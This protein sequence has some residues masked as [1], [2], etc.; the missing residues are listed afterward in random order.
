MREELL[1]ISAELQRLKSEGVRSV[2]VSEETMAKL[3]AAVE[4]KKAQSSVTATEQTSSGAALTNA[5]HA[6]PTASPDIIDSPKPK[7]IAPA[8]PASVQAKTPLLPAAPTISLPTGGKQSRWDFLKDLVQN[9]PVCKAHLYPGKKLVLGDGNLDAKIM[10][11]GEAPGAE[12]E[13]Q[14]VPFVGR[15]GELLSKM[16]SA[17]GLKRGDVYIGN[18]MNWRPELERTPSGIQI[19][20]RPPTPEEMA[21]C[22]PFLK[23]QIEII[24]PD[25]LVAMGATAAAGLLGQG[26]FK[27]LGEVRGKWREFSGKPVMITYH[28]S[29]IL[30]NNSNR[31]KR[32][33]WED[34]L[35]V[36]ERAS[37]PVSE[38]Q[39]AYFL[40]K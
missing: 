28:P 2:S 16:I 1:A 3:R 40:E 19:G 15:A 10:F 13:E 18:I 20:N 24:Q 30:R 38:K 7:P 27:A 34:L 14:G 9:N 8:A 37:L 17:M 5:V 21:F 11:V 23:A 32:M 39:R 26:T 6:V 25:L 12:E 36:M 4:K 29:Y 22:L 35:L 33:I 31:S